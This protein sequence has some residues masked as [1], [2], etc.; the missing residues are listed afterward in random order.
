[1]SIIFNKKTKIIATYGPACKSTK[2]IENLIKNGTDL[3]RL[4]M[5][6]N[7]D[8]TELSGIVKNIRKTAKKLD[9]HIGIF[10]DLQGP[11]IRLGEFENGS[12]ILK[13]NQ[14]VTL[15]SRKIK[16]S[17]KKMYVDYEHIANDVK[18]GD[19]VFIDDGK[20]SLTVTKIEGT[21]VIC[22]INI[23][24]K[25][26]N[27]KGVNFPHT[28]LSIPAF[29]EKDKR[30][31]LTGI[32]L[33]VDYIAL[34][35]VST[36]Y[37]VISFKEYLFNSGGKSIKIISKIEKK[38][39]IENHVGIIEESDA[40]MVARGDLGVEVGL[41]NVPKLQKQI[42]QE[43]NSKI[44]PVIVATQMLESMIQSNTATRAEVSDIA[45]AIYD[46][47]DAVMLSGETAVGTDPANVVI[48]IT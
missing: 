45:N 39:A 9:K 38:Q 43:C 33:G 18:I 47:C 16:C 44:K 17:D 26:S 32:K 8:A 10:C 35:F 24:G 6:H 2:V 28:V 25:V 27:H 37:D 36:K 3:F 48:L 19:V 22:K 14:F 34:S 42:I 40:I 31:A 15:T 5:S 46:N 23:G 4:N 13:D 20:L 29:T 7:D 41:E 11:K 21:D 12:A 30:D 1:M